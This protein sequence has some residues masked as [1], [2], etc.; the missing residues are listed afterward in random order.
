MRKRSGTSVLCTQ[1]GKT[2]KESYFKIGKVR[3]AR[4]PIH[5]IKKIKPIR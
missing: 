3:S 1:K 5:K 2:L 4:S